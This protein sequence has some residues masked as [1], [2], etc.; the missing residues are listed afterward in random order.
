MRERGKCGK[1]GNSFNPPFRGRSDPQ[2][3]EGDCSVEQKA[4][5]VILRG[6]G[7]RVGRAV[8]RVS[9]G[10][11][12]GVRRVFDGCSTGVRRGSDVSSDGSKWLAFSGLI[13]FGGLGRLHLTVSPRGGI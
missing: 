1:S 4:T 10:C 13:G 7:R 2:R 11:S 8:R 5:R 9:D 3:R 12:T 6:V